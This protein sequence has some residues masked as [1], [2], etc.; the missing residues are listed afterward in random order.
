MLLESGYGK[1]IRSDQTIDLDFNA[2]ET[3]EL[4]G[5]VNNPNA[6]YDGYVRAATLV[7]SNRQ[8]NPPQA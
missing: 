1:F 4:L 2:L 5:I 8:N 6:Y 3:E 7:L